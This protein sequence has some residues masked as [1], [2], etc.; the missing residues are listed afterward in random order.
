MDILILYHHLI[1]GVPD[2]FGKVGEHMY[3][4]EKYG[5]IGTKIAERISKCFNNQ[6]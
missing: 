1:M 6:Q 4:L 5:L 2:I 3:L